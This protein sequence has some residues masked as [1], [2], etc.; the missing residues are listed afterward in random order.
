MLQWTQATHWW[1]IK[2]ENHEINF[3]YDWQRPS[4]L[5]LCLAFRLFF[6]TVTK[7]CVIA[8]YIILKNTY[9]MFVYKSEFSHVLLFITILIYL[10]LNAMR[11]LN[12]FLIY[13]TRCPLE[14]EKR[15]GPT[16]SPT[17]H[18][19]RKITYCLCNIGSSPKHR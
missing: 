16:F 1:Q 14:V 5:I 18:K 19:Y 3:Q 10:L 8:T 13:D 6:Y 2:I 11:L 7:L 17:R 4:K 15:S 12:L 9:S